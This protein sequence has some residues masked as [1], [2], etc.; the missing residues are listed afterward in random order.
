MTSARRRLRRRR[1]SKRGQE[2]SVARNAAALGTALL[3]VGSLLF[4]TPL[5]DLAPGRAAQGPG[6]IESASSPATSN[7][8]QAVCRLFGQ[9]TTLP[10]SIAPAPGNTTGNPDRDPSQAL[11]AQ[12][13]VVPANASL[14]MET[15]TADSPVPAAAL[16]LEET[17]AGDGQM[18]ATGGHEEAAALEG[19]QSV[20]AP[21]PSERIVDPEN[22]A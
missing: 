2:G 8:S 9:T 15:G 13:G 18:L 7:N 21:S 12:A 14:G 3:A 11:P 17:V 1:G 20:A 5:T 4:A 19:S 22:P 10:I 6:L 16:A